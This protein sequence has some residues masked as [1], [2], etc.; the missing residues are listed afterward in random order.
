MYP[1]HNK[2]GPS[3]ELPLCLGSPAWILLQGTLVTL[4]LGGT[5]AWSQSSKEVFK[6]L[7]AGRGFIPCYDS[8]S[9]KRGYDAR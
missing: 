4:R 5:W 3:K 9:M 8:V 1:H 2:S 7:L 6:L